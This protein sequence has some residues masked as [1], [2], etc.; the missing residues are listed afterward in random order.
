MAIQRS[1]TAADES[2]YLDWVAAHPAGY[3]VNALTPKPNPTELVLHLGAC[4]TINELREARTTFT[5]GQYQKVCSST[6]GELQV[7][8]ERVG[9]QLRA[10]SFCQR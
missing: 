6:R 5:G 8:A 9:S 10:C 7:R 3:V 2:P 1:D 4:R